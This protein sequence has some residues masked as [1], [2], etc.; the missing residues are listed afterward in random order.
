[1]TPVKNLNCAMSGSI[2]G[3]VGVSNQDYLTM[4]ENGQCLPFLATGMSEKSYTSLGGTCTFY[5]VIVVF[6]IALVYHVCTFSE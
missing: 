3:F 6:M 4:I 2:A 1:M 5:D